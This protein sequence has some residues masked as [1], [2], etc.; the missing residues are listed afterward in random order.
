VIVTVF[1]VEE[2]KAA[3]GAGVNTAVTVEPTG[4]NPKKMA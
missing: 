4:R 2:V 1:D 3:P